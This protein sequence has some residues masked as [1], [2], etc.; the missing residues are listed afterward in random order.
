MSDEMGWHL[1]LSLIAVDCLLCA[2]IVRKD[3]IEEKGRSWIHLREKMKRGTF[4]DPGVLS[5]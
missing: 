1:M 2:K 4:H 5:N 3:L